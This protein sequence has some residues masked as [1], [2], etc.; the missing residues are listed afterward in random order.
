MSDPASPNHLSPVFLAEMIDLTLAGLPMPPDATSERIAARRE[1]ARIS[2]LSHEPRT[3]QEA[4]LASQ[5]TLAQYASADCFRRI[6]APD[7]PEA[8][9]VRQHNNAAAMLRLGTS[10]INELLRCQARRVAQARAAQ[11]RAMP[12][13]APIHTAQ[14]AAPAPT[15]RPAA[16]AAPAPRPQHNDPM[17]SGKPSGIVAPPAAFPSVAFDPAMLG[18]IA[19]RAVAAAS[20]RP[21]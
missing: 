13:A 10:L 5:I 9:R 18:E 16:P 19:R 11:P 1:S 17:Q 7:T 2:L 4:M 12:A 21:A 14:P 3:P 20:A 8:L 15:A 6:A